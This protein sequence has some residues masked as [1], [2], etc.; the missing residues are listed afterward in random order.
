MKNTNVNIDF[1]GIRNLLKLLEAHGFDRAELRKISARIA[2]ETGA[3]IIFP[4]G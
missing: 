3:D 2:A 4:A 1:C